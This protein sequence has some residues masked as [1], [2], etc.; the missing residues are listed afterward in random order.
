MKPRLETP[1][2]L[3]GIWLVT[4]EELAEAMRFDGVK[5]AFRKWCK[6]IGIEPVPGRRN[7]YDPKLVRARL[8]AAQGMQTPS[9]N[10][11]AAPTLSLVEQR[12]MRRD[13]LSA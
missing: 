11:E 3:Q 5:G 10:V 9:A 13:S 12:R 8:D 2:A 7:L 4:G 6:D 1:T